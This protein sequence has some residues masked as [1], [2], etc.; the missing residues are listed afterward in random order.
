M[1]KIFKVQVIFYVF[2]LL[3]AGT[4]IFTVFSFKT[5][6]RTISNSQ[7][8]A[9]DGWKITFPDGSTKELTLPNRVTAEANDEIILSN[10]IDGEQAGQTLAF[11]T[12]NQSV[13]VRLDGQKLYE[14]GLNNQQAFGKSPGSLWHYVQI[15]AQIEKGQLE[16][17]LTS[18][19]RNLGGSVGE[20]L[21]GAKSSCILRFMQEEWFGLLCGVVLLLFGLLFMLYHFAMGHLKLKNTG[22]FQLGMSCVLLAGN[23]II[24][25][26]LVQIFYG[27]SSVYYIAAYTLLFLCLIPFLLYLSDTIFERK[28]RQLHICAGVFTISFGVAFVLQIWNI[29]D[30]YQYRPVFFWMSVALY[31]YLFGLTVRIFYERKQ[32]DVHVMMLLLMVVQGALLI[33]DLLTRL[34]GKIWYSQYGLMVLMLFLGTINISK[35][36]KDYRA[37]LDSRMQENDEKTKELLQEHDKLLQEI[38]RLRESKER[39]DRYNESKSIFLGSVSKK[40]LG[41]ISN[42]MGMTELILHDEIS[43]SIKEKL[44]SMQ[45]AGATALMLSNNIM[46]YTQYETN[47]LELKCVAYPVDKLLYDMNE[48]VSVALIEKNVDF[49]V[50]FSPDIPREL[51]G[52]EIR[53][54]QIL[55]TI[56]ANAVRYTEEGSIRFKVDA[57]IGQ[58]DEVLLSFTI[59]DTG[60]GISKENLDMLFDMFLL[61]NSADQVA[62][63]G[64]GL[65]VCKKLIDLMDGTIEV[66]SRVG[67]GTMFVLKIPQ[68]IIN[69]LPIVEVANIDFKTLVYESNLL[70]KMM[71]KKVFMELNLD[72]EFAVNDEEFITKLDSGVY[73]TVLICQ[74]QYDTHREYLEQPLN[75]P[76]RKVVMADIANTIQSY[77]NADIL[78]RPIQ[79]MNLYDAI[80]GNEIV[81]PIVMDSTNQFVAPQARILIVDDSPANLKIA[82][83]LMERYKMNIQTA[84]SGTAC[85]EMLMASMDYDMVFLDYSMPG[86]GGVETL[87]TLREY[88]D[89]YYKTLPVIA[90]TIPMVNGAK[91]LFLEEGFDDYIPKP[92]EQNSLNAILEK[93]L[94]EEKIIRSDILE[95]PA[96]S[97]DS[98]LSEQSRNSENSDNTE[99]AGKPHTGG[100]LL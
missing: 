51:F 8:A 37:G 91:E 71:L 93:F 78:Q 80:S 68:K 17:V 46:D 55:S 47:T 75:A 11:H 16:I 21:Y 23:L 9:P 33:T 14:F 76:V 60:K 94:P 41:P 40:L 84:V 35:V 45:T 42:I 61:Y 88:N 85:L 96:L 81:E 73:H 24:S 7:I 56:L 31:L 15:P 44:Y 69:G 49:I 59:A 34:H 58:A 50:D 57:Q 53:I 28:K 3:A 5:D 89:K 1:K 65:A 18:P 63:N 82:T 38:E 13:L 10:T 77:E 67:E 74:S 6:N 100:E 32:E 79:C 97:E 92:M 52:D 86:V 2:L 70:Q 12:S 36:V 64:L 30:Y 20:V 4:I 62:G 95:E 27:N 54:R 26:E 29:V 19:F 25:T 98:E 43:D 90:M 83:G 48:S 22:M 66:E 99:V 72:V 87:R 39:A